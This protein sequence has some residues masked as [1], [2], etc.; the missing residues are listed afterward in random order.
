MKIKIIKGVYGHRENGAVVPKDKNSEPFE[1]EDKKAI[2]LIKSGIAEKF[3][4]L[5][6]EAD[7]PIRYSESLAPVNTMKIKTDESAELNNNDASD[8]TGEGSEDETEL[9]LVYSMDNTQKELL[10]MAKQLGFDGKDS[11]TKA[12]LIEFLDEATAGDA[13]QIGDDAGV[14]V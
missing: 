3:N 11:T 8:E 9:K 14:V 13:P 7:T 5:K 2:D 4:G 1:V 10:A 12:E 6:S